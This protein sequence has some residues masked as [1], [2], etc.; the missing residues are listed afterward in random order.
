MF[1]VQPVQLFNTHFY[2]VSKL[3][4]C[5]Q[6]QIVNYVI[7]CHELQLDADLT[8]VFMMP[9]TFEHDF[10][11]WSP[12]QI[13]AETRL[14]RLHN[15]RSKYS[16][17]DPRRIGVCQTIW[18]GKI[19]ERFYCSPAWRKPTTIVRLDQIISFDSSV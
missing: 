10:I 19:F 12:K 16:I 9:F 2:T 11:R 5:E 18:L 3:T 17:T 7:K 14:K 15:Y 6:L 8:F 13:G 4:I 1:N